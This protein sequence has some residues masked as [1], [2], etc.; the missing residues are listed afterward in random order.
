MAKLRQPTPEDIKIFQSFQKS[1]LPF[2]NIMWHLVPQPVKE[3]YKEE[4][5]TLIKQKKLNEIKVHHF[6][7]FIRGKHLTWQQ[8]LICLAVKE[9]LKPNGIKRISIASGHG[10]GKELCNISEILM[11]DGTWKKNG[12]LIP[13]DIIWGRNGQPTTILDV[14]PQGKKPLYRVT[15]DD[16]SSILAGLE[17]QWTV[18]GRQQRRNKKDWITITTEDIIEAGIKR[19]NGPVLARQWEIPQLEPLN[20]NICTPDAYTIGVWLG[21][22]TSTSSAYT[23]PD[24]QLRE[25]IYND[26][27]NLSEQ[28]NKNT[29]TVYGLCTRLKELGIFNNKKTGLPKNFL[30]WDILSK[31]RLLA[32]LVDTDGT[33]SQK[34]NNI[35]FGSIH[36][37]LAEDALL[38][39]RSLGGKG[40][41]NIKPF[42]KFKYKGET[43]TGRKYYR[44]SFQTPFNPFILRRK[45]SLWHKPEV[46]YLS[47]WIDSIK[48]EKDAPA[49]CIRVDNPEALYVAGRD[50]IVTHN[51]SL[52]AM[53]IIW[54]LYTFPCS[55]VPCTA[56][57]GDQLQGALWKEIAVWMSR[58]P[59]QESNRFELQNDHLRVN[60]PAI[61]D[62]G[63][64]WWARARTGKKE[65]PEA[66]AGIH[67]KNVMVIVDEA[68]YDEHTEV[69]TDSG[70]KFF[71]DLT[72]NDLVLSMDKNENAIFD[73]PLK[74]MEYE[75]EREMY[76]YKR[77]GAD[78]AV[79]SNHK[80]LYSNRRVSRLRLKEIKDIERSGNVYFPRKVNF[81]LNDDEIFTVAGTKSAKHDHPEM[82]F[83]MKDWVEFVAWYLS[84]GCIIG[85]YKN[86]I[87]I[88]Q[89]KNVNEEKFNSILSLLDRMGLNYKTYAEKEIKITYRQI[90]TE[91]N[92]YGKGFK[93]KFIPDYIKKSKYANHFLNTFTLGDG[94]FRENRRIFYSSSKKMISDLQ[95]MLYLSGSA[96]T[97][98][99]RQ[100]EDK[101]W[102]KDHYIKA[103]CMAYVLVERMPTKIKY[104]RSG[105]TVKTHTGKVYC[106]ETKY[107]NV[108]TRR[109][110]LCMWGGNSGVHDKVFEVMEGA[111]TEENVIVLMITNYTRCV[112]YFHNSQTRLAHLHQTFSFSSIDSPIPSDGYPEQIEALY[113]K[114]SDQY[115]VRVLGLP[116]REE[117]VDDKGY[118]TLFR[119]QDVIQIPPP[120]S[121]DADQFQDPVIMGVDPAGEGVDKSTVIIRDGFKAQVVLEEKVSNPKQL[122][123]RV[124]GLMLHYNVK[125]HNVFADMFGTGAEF[126]KE[127]ALAGYDLTSMTV[128]ERPTSEE[129][130][131]LYLNKR[132]A[133]YFKIKRWIRQGGELVQHP[134]W[135]SELTS[136]R[137]RRGLSG[138][139]QIMSK[140]DMKAAGFPSPNSADA[141]M[142][143]FIED[144][145]ATVIRTLTPSQMAAMANNHDRENETIRRPSR[146]SD[147][148]SAV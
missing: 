6:A 127:M 95:E 11:H 23:K 49:T 35:E 73:K 33:I 101:K 103:T 75:G 68:C 132:A 122:A 47:R 115:R 111:L 92:K 19:S 65:N 51:S 118:V 86:V 27:Y 91:L 22:G 46:R 44:V 102:Y 70:F 41:I 113:G 60:D 141:L 18:K 80:M 63:R 77:R 88:T 96:G 1:P 37:K 116:P 143:T 114:D 90:A 53:L 124:I 34:T 15:F 56:P 129:D 17:H 112:G 144:D 71:K 145:Q 20:G 104:H 140:K 50:L 59:E 40:R 130:K 69:L 108:F 48:Y 109:N 98:C 16:G 72:D 12:D 64:I 57:T 28:K 4:V 62:S 58:M 134:T 137:Y 126:V 31:K 74:R 13:G 106:V 146:V 3:E 36:K 25:E 123:R 142:L 54:F 89:Q 81:E 84:E 135:E 139:I 82:T 136:I 55:N 8:W 5:R 119:A 148:F 100:E 7:P 9:A 133:G 61:K 79:T 128:G 105:L 110:G 52:N 38:L 147:P 29:Q 43:R 94:Y 120:S 107:G 87:N 83:K 24:Q 67:S 42:P 138:K 99:E 78:F 121:N 76:Y 45:A 66:L 97:L 21:D 30:A 26:G 39:I 2:I 93:N 85:K 10:V 14:Y 32:G 125:P 117:A 131:E